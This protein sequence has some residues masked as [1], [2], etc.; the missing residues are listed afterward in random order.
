[1]TL[2]TL[3]AVSTAA[4]LAL[5][6]YAGELT[7]AE[8]AAHERLEAQMEA[9]KDLHPKGDADLVEKLATESTANVL[10]Q[11]NVNNSQQPE[12]KEMVPA[13]KREPSEVT[14]SRG[15]AATD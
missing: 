12:A 10:L 6:A 3:T 4:L 7:E 15:E 14:E 9:A 11:K 2:K 1:M 8:K 13:A 5:P